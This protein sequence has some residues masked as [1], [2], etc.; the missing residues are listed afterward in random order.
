MYKGSSEGRHTILFNAW[1]TPLLD[2]RLRS[3]TPRAGE[4]K[5][6]PFTHT[7]LR[8]PGPCPTPASSPRG[9]TEQLRAHTPGTVHL[10]RWAPSPGAQHFLVGPGCW[11]PSAAIPVIPHRTRTPGA[12]EDRGQ[13]PPCTGE[14]RRAPEGTPPISPGA[15]A[16]LRPRQRPPRQQRA[17]KL[18]CVD[19][20]RTGPEG[21]HRRPTGRQGGWSRG[22]AR[23]WRPPPSP[24][25]R[26]RPSWAGSGQ[27]PGAGRRRDGRRAPRKPDARGSLARPAAARLLPV[28][29][30]R[31]RAPAR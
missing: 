9:R 28:G 20:A 7:P 18:V 14:A 17:P 25:P 3:Q 11:S 30:R 19:P 31:P 22:A 5:T 15:R 16:A 24:L 29:R 6:S 8:A 1:S 27:L 10:A 26:S 13:Q 23:R 4:R 21:A 12:R 2:L